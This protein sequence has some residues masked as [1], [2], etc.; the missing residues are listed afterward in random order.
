MNYYVV[1]N[2]QMD[3]FYIYVTTRTHDASHTSI[4]VRICY[5]HMLQ[6]DRKYWLENI[7]LLGFPFQHMF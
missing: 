5:T 7:F 3:C 2:E 6:G 4:T 1:Q